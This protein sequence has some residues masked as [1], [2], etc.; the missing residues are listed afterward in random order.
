MTRYLLLV[1]LLSSS[2]L[3]FS[4]STPDPDLE[5][6][7]IS[8]NEDSDDWHIHDPSNV[9]THNKKHMIAVTGKE[10][11]SNYPCG[12]ETWW[13]KKKDRGDWKPGQCLLSKKPQWV[14]KH[15]PG[16][17]GAYWAPTL[18]RRNALIYS[19]SDGF[20]EEGTTCLGV[21]KATG[22]FPDQLTWTDSGK[23]LTCIIGDQY[24]E[25]RSA[26]DPDVFLG[27][28]KKTYLVTG[29]GVIIGTELKPWSLMPKSGNWFDKNDPSW[30]EMARGPK[31]SFR[32]YDWVEAAFIYPNHKTNYYYLFVNW[33]T[34]CS[35]I[36]STYN[37]RVG[38]SRNPLGPYV[39]KKGKDLMKGGG[40]LFLKERSYM[41]GPGHPAI[42]QKGSKE[43][44]TFHYYDTRRDGLPWIAERWLKWNTKGWPY[45]GGLRSSYE[46]S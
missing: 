39:D 20:D 19:V 16:N 22:T 21:A 37:I 36:K 6:V 18:V 34:C 14:E 27:F 3:P 4:S 11:T 33:G 9:V 2:L 28:D 31:I 29:G 12:L 46:M 25:E 17:D 38:R 8:N 41:V 1:C 15:C 45:A 43:I 42:Y 7:Y 13:R 26:I 44:L 23:P 32:E 30:K 35:G 5:Q 10:P 24:E 40:S